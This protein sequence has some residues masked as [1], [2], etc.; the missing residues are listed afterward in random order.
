MVAAGEFRED[1]LYRLNL[2][3]IH[4]PPLRERREDIP[5]LAARFLQTARKCTGAIRSRSA[6]AAIRWLQAQPWPGNVRQLRQSVER[7]VLVSTRRSPRRRGLRATSDEPVRA[8]TG[9]DAAAAGR[10]R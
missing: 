8:R 10:D 1:L 4:L 9:A 6:A 5:I 7:A 2:I 3:A